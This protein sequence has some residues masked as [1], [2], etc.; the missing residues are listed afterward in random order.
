MPLIAEKGIGVELQQAERT[1]GSDFLAASPFAKMPALRDEDF[2]I[3]D[4]TAI[5]TYL[6]ALK[7]EPNLIPLDPKAGSAAAK[8]GWRSNPPWPSLMNASIVSYSWLIRA[9]KSGRPSALR[10]ATGT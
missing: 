1:P 9:R 7:P 4:S 5:V 2:T 3:S 6:D 10:S 8:I